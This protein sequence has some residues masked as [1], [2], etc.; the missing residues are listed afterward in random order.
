MNS[1]TNRRRSFIASATA[2]LRRVRKVL[3]WA[4]GGLTISLLDEVTTNQ[5]MAFFP[6]CPDST[7]LAYLA[8]SSGGIPSLAG[9][10]SDPSGTSRLEKR[11]PF[12]TS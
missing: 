5:T 6:S 4:F 1:L 2:R 8:R 3:S 7:I 9:K 11:S 12:V 10:R